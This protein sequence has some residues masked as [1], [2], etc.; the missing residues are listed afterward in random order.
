MGNLVQSDGNQQCMFCLQIALLSPI[1]YQQKFASQPVS[2]LPSAQTLRQQYLPEGTSSRADSSNSP[3]PQNGSKA[4]G[5]AAAGPGSNR[6]LQLPFAE[7]LSVAPGAI[8]RS[9]KR[10]SAPG[11]VLDCQVPM[12]RHCVGSKGVCA[13]HSTQDIAGSSCV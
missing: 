11:S 5:A 6:A 9:A 10:L 1:T 3:G 12:C 7:T 8:S 2:Q 4:M 13:Q